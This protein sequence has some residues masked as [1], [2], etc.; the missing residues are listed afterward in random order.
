MKS[1]EIINDVLHN[2]R[3]D[4]FSENF[5]FPHQMRGICNIQFPFYLRGFSD[6]MK[7]QAVN[8]AGC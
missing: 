7:V 2:G 8:K 5:K 3:V 4:A 6:L 1:A